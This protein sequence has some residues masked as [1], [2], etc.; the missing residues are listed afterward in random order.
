MYRLLK[1][2]VACTL[3]VTLLAIYLFWIFTKKHTKDNAYINTDLGLD[4]PQ[5]YPVTESQIH[6]EKEEKCSFLSQDLIRLEGC[7]NST[8]YI[9]LHPGDYDPCWQ[10][11]EAN[12]SYGFSAFVDGRDRQPRIKVTIHK[13][14]DVIRYWINIPANTRRWPNARL[15]LAHRLRRWPNVSPPLGQGIV[16]AGI[17]CVCRVILATLYTCVYNIMELH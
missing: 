15:T 2:F 9:P 7:P 13:K 3:I 10:V 12:L 5:L 6:Q 1:R 8:I 16:F 11:V 14:K 17:F 4:P